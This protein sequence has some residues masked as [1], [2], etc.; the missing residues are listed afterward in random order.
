MVAMFHSLVLLF[1]LCISV[2]VELTDEINAKWAKKKGSL[3]SR[4]APLSVLIL[5]PLTH[6]SINM[7]PQ[8]VKA[9]MLYGWFKFKN[10]NISKEKYDL[11]PKYF[12]LED[13][14]DEPTTL[15]AIL[16]RSRDRDIPRVRVDTFIL[17]M[18]V[19]TNSSI[20]INLY[21]LDL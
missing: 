18:F 3:E 8:E 4:P 12:Y 17:V 11:N 5:Q 13:S 19:N 20:S 2:Y 6:R 7:N 1:S 14:K 21:L 9:A 16:R 15:D 10:F